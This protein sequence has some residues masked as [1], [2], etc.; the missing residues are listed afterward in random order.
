VPGR[1]YEEF[2]WPAGLALF[3]VAWDGL[4]SWVLPNFLNWIKLIW[5][6][7]NKSSTEVFKVN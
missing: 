4:K 5:H 3:D 7:A 2:L 6:R 1:K